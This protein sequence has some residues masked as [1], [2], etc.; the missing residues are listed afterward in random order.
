MFS[1]EHLINGGKSKIIEKLAHILLDVP[2]LANFA[3]STN[4]TIERLFF[5]S[6]HALH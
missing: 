3:S 6:T 5:D 2:V 1:N 4:I